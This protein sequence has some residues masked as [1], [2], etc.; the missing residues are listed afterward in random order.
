MCCETVFIRPSRTALRFLSPKTL[1]NKPG[2]TSGQ[3]SGQKVGPKFG[4]ADHVLKTPLYTVDGRKHPPYKGINKENKTIFPKLSEFVF[5]IFALWTLDFLIF[6]LK[7]GFLIKS[8]LYRQLETSRIPDFDE[9]SS[10]QP[11]G[12][13]FPVYARAM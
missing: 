10:Q 9:Q 3:T 7:I 8:C 12:V 2:Q 1:A 5:L 6:V 11:W 4:H 13:F